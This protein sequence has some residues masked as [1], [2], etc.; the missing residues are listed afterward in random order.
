MLLS[1]L[2]LR[3]RPPAPPRR[4]ALLLVHTRFY[5]AVDPGRAD[6]RPGAQRRRRAPTIWGKRSGT[7]TCCVV[8]AGCASDLRPDSAS[9]PDA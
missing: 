5:D 2:R 6:R 4:R 7:A 1:R 3:R 8:A 9:A